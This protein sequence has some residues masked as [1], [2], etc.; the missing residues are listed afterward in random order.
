M[1]RAATAA[2]IPFLLDLQDRPEFLPAIGSDDAV[3][4]QKLIDAPER[5]VLIWQPAGE[6]PAGVALL[7]LGR[8]DASLVELT[9]FGMV[10]QN[11]GAGGTALAQ[12]FAY[13]FEGLQA[14]RFYLHVAEDNLRAQRVYERAGMRHEG[15]LRQHWKRRIGDRTDLRIYG[16]LAEEWR[17][18][19]A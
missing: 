12:L 2:D 10:S 1:F 11:R 16:L 17:D 8:I 4:W 19:T 15:T 5:R 6:N 9:R 18:L 14:F 13:A 3:G 7:T